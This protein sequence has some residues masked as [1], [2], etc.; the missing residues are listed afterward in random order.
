MKGELFV[1]VSY[2]F[3]NLIIRK[4]VLSRGFVLRILVMPDQGPCETSSNMATSQHVT[5]GKLFNFSGL[6]FAS[7]QNGDNNSTLLLGLS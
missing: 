4:N 6:Q 5:L 1:F 2:L 7:L 3:G